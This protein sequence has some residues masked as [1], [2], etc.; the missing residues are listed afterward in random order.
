MIAGHVDG[1]PFSALANCDRETLSLLAAKYGL[2]NDQS[3]LK[4]DQKP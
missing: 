3:T 2:G 1:Y 4:I